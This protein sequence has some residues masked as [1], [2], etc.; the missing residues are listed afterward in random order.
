MRIHSIGIT[1]AES[2]RIMYQEA[3]AVDPVIRALQEW[4]A[5][6]TAGPL[7]FMYSQFRQVG[8]K[9][10]FGDRIYI[11]QCQS[12][13]LQL[14]NRYHD[15]VS[16]GQ[17]GVRRTRSKLVE[18]YFWPEMEKDIRNYVKTCIT[19]QRNSDRNTLL[20]G[21]LHPLAVPTDRFK[22]ISIDFAKINKSTS[23]YDSLMVVVCRLTKLV[24]L[25]PS[26]TDDDT[27]KIAL[28]FIKNWYSAGYGLPN[29]IISDR[30]TKFSSELWQSISEQLQIKVNLSTARHQ[31][32][33]GQAEIAIRTY[34]RTAKKFASIS[35]SDWDEQVSM[36]EFCLNYSIS[37]STGFTPFFL[38]FGFRPRTVPV[39]YE[40]LNG[41]SSK[42]K[43]S[44]AHNLLR[45]ITDSISKAQQAISSAQLGQAEQYNSKRRPSPKYAV[46][47]LVFL[48]SDGINWPS[49]SSSPKESIPSYLGPF[50]IS[51]V[52]RNRDNVTLL[53]PEQIQRS[54]FHPT[55][56]TSKLKP[57]SDR[58]LLF[59]DWQD[60]FERPGP[61][62][63]SSNLFEV[64]RILNKRSFRKQTQYL[65]GFRGYPNSANEWQTFNPKLPHEWIDEWA[66]LQAFDPSVGP[67]P[68]RDSTPYSRPCIKTSSSS[69]SF[70]P[71]IVVLR[72]SKRVLQ[73]A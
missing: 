70:K 1:E 68:S 27:K 30:D 39:D 13:K 65:I 61:I 9:W 29:S 48:S 28:R 58:A 19:C 38:A 10:F 59:P 66:I 50:F 40:F 51:H 49:Y 63:G 46:G 42:T 32:T 5:N 21:E 67:I 18:R 6:K 56:H 2:D 8:V 54:R 36:M 55:F 20:P 43:E 41:R 23:G 47:D 33:D 12:L 22:D 34:K 62:L 35:N 52:D 17:Q 69:S 44:E 25:I 64:D 11:P 24:R 3:A 26:K 14:L 37:A 53:F 31:Q 60:Q 73:S 57:F 72:R 4:Q 45:I 16:A 15:L 7:A 71:P